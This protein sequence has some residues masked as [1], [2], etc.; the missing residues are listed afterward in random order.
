MANSGSTT[1]SEISTADNT[2]TAAV[3][4]GTSPYGV[5]VTPDG[6]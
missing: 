2:V 4:V 1:V 5:A 6:T 3:T